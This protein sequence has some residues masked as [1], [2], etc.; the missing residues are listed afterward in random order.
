M[1]KAPFDGNV[2]ARYVDNFQTV[3]AKQPVVRLLDVSK[4]E[5]TIQVPESLISLV[6]RVKKAICRFDAFAG[7]EFVG[8]VTKI[9]SEASQTTRTYP[10]TVQ[11]DQPKDVQILP[12]MAAT[13]RGQPE[14]N[15]EETG[16]DL[17]VPPSVVFT[18]DAGQQVLRLGRGGRQPEGRAAGG[19]NRQADSRRHRGHRGTQAGRV[20]GHRPECIRSARIS[21]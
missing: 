6:P 2:A 14:E 17:V 3:Q 11:L 16:E 8:Q 21:K 1:L 10:V 20:G 7:R 18:D 9:G 15:G 19:E 4:I 12:G 5:V 13:V